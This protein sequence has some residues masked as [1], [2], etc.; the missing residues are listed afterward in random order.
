MHALGLL[1]ALSLTASPAPTPTPPTATVHKLR[2]VAAADVA[3]AVTAFAAQKK[4]A[5]TVVAE[6]VTNTLFVAGDA[7]GHKQIV[8]I[9]A[10]L[11][12]TPAQVVVQMTIMK[13]PTTF[14]GELGMGECKVWELSP[15]E[16]T[17]LNAVVRRE[18]AAGVAE[19]LSRPQLQVSDNQTGHVRV[20]NDT[21][22]VSASVTPR[23]SP[24]GPMLVRVDLSV[25]EPTT[26]GRAV[27]ASMQS[28]ALISKG[29]TMLLR[30]GKSKSADGVERELFVVLT[31]HQ[32]QVESPK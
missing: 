11:D 32:V 24:T 12:V 22:G 5:V 16:M 26:N 27:S 21:S 4:L 28:T 18:Q 1:I 20:G 2:N 23:I 30:G 19:V 10:A 3:Q 9:V 17:L 25:S 7:A 29:A 8:G 14:A 31:P 13:V 6:A 15:R